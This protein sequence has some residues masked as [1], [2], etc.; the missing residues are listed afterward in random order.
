M[1]RWAL[2]ADVV[3]IGGRLAELSR[4]FMSR[5]GMFLDIPRDEAYLF[6]FREVAGHLVDKVA[7]RP[8]LYID[9]DYELYTVGVIDL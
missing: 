3:P 9:R 5:S 2:Y 4:L 8:E 7:K 1:P 6:C